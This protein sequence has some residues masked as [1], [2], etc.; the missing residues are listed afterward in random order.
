[1]KK[2]AALAALPLFALTACSSGSG[3]A[4][5]TVTVSA[6][7]S[8]STFDRTAA[9][10]NAYDQWVS[11]NI[12][13]SKIGSA[14]KAGR[15]EVGRALCRDLSGDTSWVGAVA[16]MTQD[17]GLEARDAGGYIAATVTALCP[18]NSYKLPS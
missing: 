1:M 17:A 5:K 6:T 11:E 3:D 14:D 2:L 8:S 15:L 7:P 18:E 13:D 10:E 9:G 12:A 16:A 4:A